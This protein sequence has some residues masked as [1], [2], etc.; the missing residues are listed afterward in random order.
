MNEE[1]V[2]F[3]LKLQELS[4]RGYKMDIA[5]ALNENFWKRGGV[6]VSIHTVRA[7][8][9]EYFKA[10]LDQKEALQWEVVE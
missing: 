6:I 2:T 8:S 7:G 10:V 3:N 9:L 1:D 4:R 5:H